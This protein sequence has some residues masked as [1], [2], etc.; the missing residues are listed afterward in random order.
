MKFTFHNSN[1][2]PDFAGQTFNV[3]PVAWSA[4]RGWF[5]TTK[6][7]PDWKWGVFD[8][9]GWGPIGLPHSAFGTFHK[10]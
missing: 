4:D 8:K 9:D 3:F 6:K 10:S 1:G 5:R 2:S 7:N